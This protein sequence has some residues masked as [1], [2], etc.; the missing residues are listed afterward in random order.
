MPLIVL[1]TAKIHI[2][3]QFTTHLQLHTDRHQ[4]CLLLQR[5]TFWSNSQLHFLPYWLVIHCA[6]YCKDTHFEAIHNCQADED[7]LRT[8][9]LATAKIHIL[10]QFTTTTLLLFLKL[11]LCLLLQRYTFWSNSQRSGY[12]DDC[13][14]NCACYCKDTH[15]EAIH[16]GSVSRSNAGVIVLATAKIHIL[17]QFTTLKLSVRLGLLLCLLLQRYTFWSNSQPSGSLSGLYLIV[18]ATA[19]IHILKQFTTQRFI[20]R[21]ISDCACYCKDTHFE[22][23]HNNVLSVNDLRAIVLA[24]AKIHILKQFTTSTRVH[25]LHYRLC[26]LLQRYTF[27]SNS[28]LAFLKLHVKSIVLATAKIHILKQFTTVTTG[29]RI[30]ND[31]ACYCK[32]THF[33]AIHNSTRLNISAFKIVLAT[34]KI[35]ILKQFTTKPGRVLVLGELCLLLQ[36]YTFW[37]NSQPPNGRLCKLKL[38]FWLL[39]SLACCLT[40]F[41]LA[42]SWMRSWLLRRAYRLAA[43][44]WP[45]AESINHLRFLHLCLL[46]AVR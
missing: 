22:A 17:K 19:K 27:W 44:R 20:I 26:L 13:W 41:F 1:A 18:L 35:H 28:Q 16:N 15:F 46:D 42:F 21:F 7:S 45:F 12:F 30:E 36:R 4:L 8:I 3:K 31:C 25:P 6:C 43:K 40:D 2:L 32:D 29:V 38:V 23:I 24:T 14:C 9:V 39:V 10:K 33:E 37:S 11:S 5:Y 34:A